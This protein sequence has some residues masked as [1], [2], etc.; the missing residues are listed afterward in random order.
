MHLPADMSESVATDLQAHLSC[1]AESAGIYVTLASD[2][3]KCPYARTQLMG[4]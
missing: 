2:A 3:Q 1:V 4:W